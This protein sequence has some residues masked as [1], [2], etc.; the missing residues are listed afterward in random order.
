MGHGWCSY[1][2]KSVAQVRNTRFFIYPRFIFQYKKCIKLF[3]ENISKET[4]LSFLVKRLHLVILRAYFWLI[5]EGS[6]LVILKNLY[7]MQEI[8]KGGQ[9]HADQVPLLI[10]YITLMS[11]IIVFFHLIYFI[12]YDLLQYYIVPNVNNS[13][14]SVLD[15]I[16]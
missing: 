1:K 9:P 7:M 16:A 12:L 6:F 2:Q 5:A 13:H 14:F 8:K 3:T 11:A 10:A 4:W 15:N